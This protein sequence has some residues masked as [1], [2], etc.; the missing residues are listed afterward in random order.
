MSREPIVLESSTG[1]LW[2]TL[3]EHGV[4]QWCQVQLVENGVARALGAESRPIIANRLAAFLASDHTPGLRWV[5][6]LAELHTSFYGEY[7]ADDTTLRLQDGNAQWIATLVLT[8]AERQRW[9]E[10]LANL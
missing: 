6:S 8:P 9:L 7:V 1:S 5:L 2:L 4:A 10:Q 3:D